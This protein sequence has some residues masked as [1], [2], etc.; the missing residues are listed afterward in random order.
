MSSHICST[1]VRE[2]L[3]HTRVRGR[4]DGAKEEAVGV[5][6]LVRQL[7]NHLHQFDH[8]VHQVP[9]VKRRHVLSSTG[10][11]RDEWQQEN[12]HPIMKQ[13]M[14]VPRKA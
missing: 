10:D 2:A 3:R 13:E 11:K 4:D 7:S 14:A 12:T 1:T 6:E 8:A 9:S 5:V